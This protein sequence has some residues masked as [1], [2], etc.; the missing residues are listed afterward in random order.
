[1]IF[2]DP[3]DRRLQRPAH[4]VSGFLVNP[5]RKRRS[6]LICCMEYKRP[7]SAPGDRQTGQNISISEA[8]ASTT[9]ASSDKVFG[10]LIRPW[11]RQAGVPERL[12]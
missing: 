5:L 11:G 10:S 8:V 6:S 2:P 4:A 9:E 3:A 7:R 12:E 1:L